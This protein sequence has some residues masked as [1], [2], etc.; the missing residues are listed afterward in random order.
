MKTEWR[1]LLW[2]EHEPS[3]GQEKSVV[4]CHGSFSNGCTTEGYFK[5]MVVKRGQSPC[6]LEC[7]TNWHKC[8]WRSEV[9]IACHLISI[10]NLSL[11]HTYGTKIRFPHL[12]LHQVKISLCLAPPACVC[13]H[14]ALQLTSLTTNLFRPKVWIPVWGQDREKEAELEKP[15][16]LEGENGL[17]KKGI[18]KVTQWPVSNGF[19][20]AKAGPCWVLSHEL[21]KLCLSILSLFAPLPTSPSFPSFLGF[22]D[23]W[24]PYIGNISN[25]TKNLQWSLLN[26]VELYSG[27][28]HLAVWPVLL[29]VL[30]GNCRDTWL[31]ESWWVTRPSH[32]S[33]GSPSSLSSHISS[34]L[35]SN[36]SET[37][38]SSAPDKQ[39]Q[40]L[41]WCDD[42]TRCE[43]S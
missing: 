24:M 16:D 2:R 3:P 5:E 41:P 7:I 30:S 20:M 33:G 23:K 35:C 25:K 10:A 13:V 34:P 36:K 32:S 39:M 4:G 21:L 1:G 11:F 43:G 38:I 14:A 8:L 27:P 26:R 18:R 29:G 9:Q 6:K 22:Q 37:I 31:Q 19:T 42:R 40:T 28:R 12:I 15:C 17:Q